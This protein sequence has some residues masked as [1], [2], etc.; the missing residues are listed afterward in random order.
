MTL[1]GNNKKIT[2]QDLARKLHTTPATVS[3]A[4]QNH[5]RIGK[6]MKK[7]VMELAE[8]MNYHPDPVAHHLRTG[9]GSV[10]GV[11]VPRIDRNFFASVIG[12]VERVA[13]KAGYSVIISQSNELYDNEKAA[14]KAMLA[15]KVDALAVS[16]AAETTNYS[17]FEPFLSKNIPLVFFDRTPEEL[18][19][20]K[21]QV[22]NFEAS[23]QSVIHL[24]QQGCREIVHLAGPQT[25]NV[26]RDRLNG[27]KQALADWNLPFDP[28]RVY[29]AITLE[30]G[31]AVAAQM[32]RSNSLP[33]GIFSAGDFSA[34][35][36]MHTLRE[37]GISIPDQ[38][39]VVGFA[40]EPFCDFVEPS[41]SSVDQLILP[42]G[43]EVASLLLREMDTDEVHRQPQT[44]ELTANLVIRKSSLRTNNSK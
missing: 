4:L 5:P 33:D 6:E 26:Y 43:E 7:A 15:K 32:L 9:K 13:G 3:R 2:L 28:T 31:R 35:G 34:M 39:A 12:G 10:I 20:N 18:S 27:Y 1:P 23:R 37:A 22:N 42:I 40:N 38:I 17:H 29:Q 30:T 16:L 19:A 21:I 8:Q 14:V 36:V 44:I 24:L 25:L 11:I 41:L